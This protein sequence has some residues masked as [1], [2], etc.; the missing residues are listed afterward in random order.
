MGLGGAQDL[1][2]ELQVLFW[3]QKNQILKIKFPKGFPN[4]SEN[5][6][7]T[8]AFPSVKNI[9]VSD[10]NFCANKKIYGCSKWEN[11]CQYRASRVL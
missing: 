1:T 6:L 7:R 2:V 9:L 8:N 5:A 3:S 10:R 11:K 4:H